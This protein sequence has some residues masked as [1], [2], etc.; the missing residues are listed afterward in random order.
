MLY[1]HPWIA[2][3]S[4]YHT[5]KKR[6]APQKH[7]VGILTSWLCHLSCFFTHIFFT[8]VMFSHFIFHDVRYT[9]RKLKSLR[10]MA[11]HSTTQLIANY[12]R[13]NACAVGHP[14]R[15]DIVLTVLSCAV[16]RPIRCG[17]VLTVLRVLGFRGFRGFRRFRGLRA[18]KRQAWTPI[19]S[20]R[21]H[22]CGLTF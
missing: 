17:K 21:S 6:I 12:A 2:Q 16:V 11:E 20:L 14:R 3:K 19:R 5:L 4:V 7:H 1:A 22:C 8:H 9:A 10:F 15:L 13:L 18:G